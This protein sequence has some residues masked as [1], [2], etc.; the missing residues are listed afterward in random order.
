MSPRE[1][2]RCRTRA[3]LRSERSGEPTRARCDSANPE[4]RNTGLEHPKSADV[5]LLI[6][7]A[8]TT[9]RFDRGPKRSAYARSRIQDYWIVNL[10][11]RQLEVYRAPAGARYRGVTV[12]SEHEA[13]IPLAAPDASVRVSDLLPPLS[14]P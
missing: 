5:R 11:E 12:H 6:E 2:V 9:L 13:V 1:R 4:P 7:V 3:I 8:D 14:A 10:L